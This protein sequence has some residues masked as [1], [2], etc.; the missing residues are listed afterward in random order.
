MDNFEKHSDKAKIRRRITALEIT[1]EYDPFAAVKVLFWLTWA[2]KSIENGLM[3]QKE[4]EIELEYWKISVLLNIPFHFLGKLE[5][6][7]TRS[8]VKLFYFQHNTRIR[9]LEY[10][11]FLYEHIRL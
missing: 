2:M 6:Q 5:P 8:F 10:K 11:R 1:N 4:I 3:L 9:F 7:W